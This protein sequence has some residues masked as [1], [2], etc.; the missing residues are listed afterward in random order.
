MFL[1]SGS[2]EQ[3]SDVQNTVVDDVLLSVTD[4]TGSDEETL[5]KVQD[6]KST[7]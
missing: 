3:E 4:W 7:P 2:S 6:A 1:Q 5:T